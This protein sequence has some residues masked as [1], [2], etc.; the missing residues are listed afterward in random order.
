ETAQNGWIQT[1]PSFGGCYTRS[2]N[3]TN[4]PDYVFGNT[5]GTSTT[6]TALQ[7]ANGDAVANGSNLPLGTSM[8]D[9]ATVTTFPTP[10]GAPAKTGTA[11]FTFFTGND[12]NQA[13]AVFATPVTIGNT[14]VS[15]VT[16]ALGAGDYSFHA[17]YSG[18]LNYA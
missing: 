10:Q 6:H 15:D 12:C 7:K 14:L 11:T 9:T 16:N 2:A 1:T 3:P 17:V 4:Q 13:N 5:V 18:D 8:K